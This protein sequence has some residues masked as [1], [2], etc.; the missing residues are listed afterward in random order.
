MQKSNDLSF[1]FQ[2]KPADNE[3][4]KLFRVIID[5]TSDAL[6]IMLPVYNKDRK[7]VDFHIEYSNDAAQN[8]LQ[9]T[10]EIM[11]GNRLSA[12]FPGIRKNKLFRILIKVVENGIAQQVKT[13]LYDNRKGQRKIR[14][15]FDLKV[16]KIGQ[17]IIFN[18]RNITRYVNSETN[19]RRAIDILKQ[20]NRKLHV[21]T[22]Q[23]EHDQLKLIIAETELRISDGRFRLALDGSNVTVYEMDL[24]LR[25]TW[26]YNPNKNFKTEDMI[27]KTDLEIMGSQNGEKMMMRKNLVIENQRRIC[28]EE[29]NDINGKRYYYDNI[30]EPVFDRENK[31]VG[32]NGVS[33]D[34]SERKELEEKMMKIMLDLKRSNKDLEQFAY[35]AS[36]D[37]QEPLRMISNFAGLLSRQYSPHFEETAMQY[38]SFINQG[39]QL[40]QQIIKDLLKYSRVSTQATSYRKVNCRNVLNNALNNLSV[41]INEKKAVITAEDLPE[42]E[43]DDIQIMQ[44]FQNLIHNAI[45]FSGDNT[46]EIHVSCVR[47]NNDWLFAVR[48]NGIG[49]KSEFFERIFIIFQRLQS[50]EEI[51]GSGMG[52]AI[53]QKIIERHHGRIW[54]ESEPGE[55]STFFFTI[56]VNN[57]VQNI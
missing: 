31:L 6:I 29:Y 55:G 25:Y 20:K 22:E 54:V 53:C 37:L 39:V 46:P 10:R 42:I 8:E 30:I 32:I 14:S 26:V 56:P 17:Y 7:I 5:N 35:I 50:R 43:C 15:V 18:W 44:V 19:L 13:G 36:H 33:V 24:D 1:E 12:L 48:D 4:L 45:K 49:I 38:M 16:C 11:I 41:L 52:L 2:E 27:G 51:E 28:F 3:H 57:I 9:F 34:I 21:L 47:E 40:M 23:L